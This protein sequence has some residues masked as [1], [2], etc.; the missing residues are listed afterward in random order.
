MYAFPA[1]GWN[2]RNTSTHTPSLS[3]KEEDRSREGW[4]ERDTGEKGVDP[5]SMGL[6]VEGVDE[7]VFAVV[8]ASMRDVEIA[9]DNHVF[10]VSERVA[11][12]RREQAMEA[13]LEFQSQSRRRT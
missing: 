13:H 1:C 12:A 10:P 11:N 4:G 7:V 6:F 5:Q 8:D 9:H 2:S 3:A